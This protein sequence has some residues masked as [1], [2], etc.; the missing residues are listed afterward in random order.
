MLAVHVTG[1]P[2][3]PSEFLEMLGS[4]L[5]YGID[6]FSEWFLIRNGGMGYWDY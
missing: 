2:D 4:D 6:G 1:P 5:R 3:P